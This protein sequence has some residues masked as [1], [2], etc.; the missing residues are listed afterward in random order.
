[1]TAM[2]NIRKKL[3]AMVI[4]ALVMTAMLS[5]T[6]HAAAPKNRQEEIHKD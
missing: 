6:A 4:A 5:V 3:T 2:M 1:M